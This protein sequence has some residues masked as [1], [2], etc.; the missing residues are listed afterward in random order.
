MVSGDGRP[1]RK[2]LDRVPLVGERDDLATRRHGPGAVA[3][4]DDH[5]RVL[6]LLEYGIGGHDLART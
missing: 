4:R 5:D 1:E 2:V 3:V 6:P